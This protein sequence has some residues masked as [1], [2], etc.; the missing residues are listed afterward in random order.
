MKAGNLIRLFSMLGISL[1]LALQYV[2]FKNSYVLMEHNI[3]EKCSIG[4]TKAIELDLYNRI[5]PNNERKIKFK[6]APL[7]QTKNIASD[8]VVDVK[9]TNDF[10]L[11]LQEL[12]FME[13]NGC[14]PEKLD[15]IYSHNLIQSIGFIPPHS[16]RL[17]GDSVERMKNQTKFTFYGKITEKQ[18]AEVIL[19]NP[20]GSILRQAQLIVILSIVL[21]VIIGMVLIYL[22]RSTLREAKFVSFIK[23]YTHALTHELKTPISG[24][25]MAS[26][27][28]ASGVF[29]D[30]PEARRKYYEVCKESSSKLLSTVDRILLVAKSERSKIVTNPTKVEVKPFLDKIVQVHNSSNFRRKD[31]T[32]TVN[33]MPESLV[34]VFDV[35]LIENVMNNLIDNAVKYSEQSVKID[36]SADLDKAMLRLRVKDNGF[37]ISEH[38][39]KHIFDNFER[40]NKVEKDGIDG[41]GIGLNYV[42]KVIRAHKGRISVESIEG[43]GT[44]FFIHLPL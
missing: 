4:L 7:E 19:E 41:F 6:K 38:E 3:L 33:C 9:Q 43:K 27:Q 26:S 11:L 29:E 42:N 39:V 37:G 21:V 5:N 24:I 25:Y 10:N 32:Y 30:K 13:G 40:G 34:G 20:L 8:A 35:F 12:A 2:W 23:D 1:L 22:L 36:I 44:E 28:L 17:V 31:V 14:L 18:Y 16:F 15:S